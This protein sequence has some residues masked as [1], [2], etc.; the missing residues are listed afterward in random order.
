MIIKLKSLVFC[1]SIAY[2]KSQVGVSQPKMRKLQVKVL[3]L[4]A[5]VTAGAREL[6]PAIFL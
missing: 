4:G 2:N 3:P 5:N 1:S 6:A